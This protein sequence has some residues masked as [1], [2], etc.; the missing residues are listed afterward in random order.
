MAGLAAAAGA[1]MV[2]PASGDD[3]PSPWQIG[4]YTRPWAA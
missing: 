3:A 4:C 1:V 2:A